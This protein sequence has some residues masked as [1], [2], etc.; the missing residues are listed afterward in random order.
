MTR[1]PRLHHDRVRDANAGPND[2]LGL[3]FT[4]FVE[5]AD[6]RAEAS[7]LGLRRGGG[8]FASTLLELPALTAHILAVYQRRNAAD[9]FLG[10]ASSAASLVRHG[11]RLAYEPDPGL[12][13]LG[14]AALEIRAGLDGVI[15]AGL[16]LANGPRG[17][18]K[19]QTY[20]TLTEVAVDARHNVLQLVGA[21]ATLAFAES[22]SELLVVD[23]AGLEIGDRALLVF[24]DNSA[25]AIEVAGLDL[26]G[27]GSDNLARVYTTQGL[28]ASVA[29]AEAPA[30]MLARPRLDMRR[31]GLSADPMVFAPEL[32]RAYASFDLDEDNLGALGLG[33]YHGYRVDAGGPDA[34]DHA[35]TRLYLDHVYDTL[36]VGDWIDARE[37]DD[38][39]GYRV[40]ALGT[41]SV[42]FVVVTVTGEGPTLRYFS[43]TV[44]WLELAEAG[45]QQV[46][47]A[48]ALGWHVDLATG[49]EL[50][51]ELATTGPSIESLPEPMLVEGELGFEPGALIAVLRAG[52]QS[53][54]QI[55][56]VTR[57]TYDASEDRSE[58]STQVVAGEA[59]AAGWILGEVTVVGNVVAISHGAAKRAVLGGSDGVTPLQRFTIPEGPVAMIPGGS[60]PVPALVL[61]VDD[62]AW[63]P[64]VDFADSAAEDR[65]YLLERDEDQRLCAVFGD[66]QAGAIPPSGK[67]NVVAEYRVG[68]GV[69][70]NTPA[71]TVDRIKRAHPLL[72][73]AT[74]PLAIDDGAEPAGPEQVREQA[75][76]YI[77]TFDR[78]V[79]VLDHADL[80][81]L[82]PGVARAA[83]RWDATRVALVVADSTGAGLGDETAF[84][85]FMDAR[86]DTSVE[87]R[88]VAPEAVEVGVALRV[89]VDPDALDEQ[90]R[91]D[92]I[93]ALCS[94]ETDAPGLLSFLG[95]EFGQPVY[96]SEIYACVGAVAGVTYV[97]LTALDRKPVTLAELFEVVACARHEWLSLS[98]TGLVIEVVS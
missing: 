48:T 12:S 68:V 22:Q 50:E 47:E 4:D 5:L 57:N 16:A 21:E 31:F 78:A 7:G 96:A 36:A 74:N 40:L 9:A 85:E 71:R 65:H 27:D 39:A 98:A 13:A 72:A 92:V 37:S 23:A 69:D 8:D 3:E 73:R 24:A 43:R 42:T 44:T 53:Y 62:V 15:E 90:V 60:G 59:P 25:F 28:P 58:L 33:T 63:T 87:L 32:L 17:L 49:W 10:S 54:A 29:L 14:Y 95:R 18:I 89:E 67:R 20:E 93:A 77:R 80:A 41:A 86:R 38:R 88:I 75:T 11:R 61:R 35:S 26:D 66:G 2:Y 84:R 51:L 82:Y 52:D 91:A 70:A 30:Q 46:V 45:T 81:L 94:T 6:A 1:P 64:V 79:S 83:A 34:N 97:E 55:R 76:R 56:R 19:A